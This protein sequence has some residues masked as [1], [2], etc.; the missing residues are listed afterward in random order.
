VEL[1][2]FQ[3]VTQVFQLNTNMSTDT[4]KFNVYSGQGE[5]V[6]FSLSEKL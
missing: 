5:T 6:K 4:G 3:D 1:Q 2:S